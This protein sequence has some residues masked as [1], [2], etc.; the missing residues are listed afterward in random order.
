MKKSAVSVMADYASKQLDE[1]IKRT[2]QRR[3]E[4]E[5]DILATERK[6]RKAEAG[7]KRTTKKSQK[8]RDDPGIERE[9]N[10]LTTTSDTY[11]KYYKRLTIRSRLFSG[12][13]SVEYT[14]ALQW[15]DQLSKHDPCAADQY[16]SRIEQLRSYETDEGQNR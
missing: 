11:R 1:M 16:R 10:R 15:L 3:A 12:L 7:L 6:I 5:K 14:E 9:L 13:M 2:E 8:I 4:Y